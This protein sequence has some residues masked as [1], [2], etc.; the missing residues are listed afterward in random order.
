MLENVII[1]SLLSPELNYHCRRHLHH[2]HHIIIVSIGTEAV[3]YAIATHLLL[4]LSNR[5]SYLHSAI[6]TTVTINVIDYLCHTP[7]MSP[8]GH[9][10]NCPLHHHNHYH[11]HQIQVKILHLQYGTAAQYYNSNHK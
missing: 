8:I 7:L 1:L 3:H 10:C 2:H 5:H 9:C 11:H 6:T 4:P